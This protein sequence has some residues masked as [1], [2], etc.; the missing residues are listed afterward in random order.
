MKKSTPD[1]KRYFDYL[2]KAGLGRCFTAAFGVIT[3]QD[4][5]DNIKTSVQMDDILNSSILD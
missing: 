4:C 2:T 3:L 1:Y 5:I